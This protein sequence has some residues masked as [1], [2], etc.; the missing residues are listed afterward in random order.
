MSTKNKE[1]NKNNLERFIE[2]SNLQYENALKEIQNGKK[3]SHWIWYIF[4]QLRGLG[5]SQN[6]KFYGINDIDEAKQYLNHE[7]L[8]PR[9]IK[10]T[11]TLLNL[12]K[13][14]PIEIFGNIDS[15]K[16][17]SCMTLFYYASKNVLFKNVINKYYKGEFCNNT[18]RKLKK[19]TTCC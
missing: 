14:D 11:E 16:V 6:S 7:I 2:P 15:L 3:E 19:K 17:K 9:L 12:N 8:G 1:D 18:I 5:F 13:N 10:I 4:P